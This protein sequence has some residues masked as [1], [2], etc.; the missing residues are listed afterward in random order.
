M[1][2]GSP[3]GLS[4]SVT[5]GIISATERNVVG[6]NKYESFLQTDAAINPG[7]SGGPMVDMQGRVVGINSAIVTGSRRQR[8]RRLRHPDRHGRHLADKLIKDGKVSY[9]RVG[10]KLGVAHPGDRQAVR[11]RPE[12]QGR[13][14]RRG[15]AGEPGRQ[16][17]PEGRRRHHLVQRQARR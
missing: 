15:P 7:N 17:G 3:F 14:G 9:A 6:I 16:G 8:R 5:T 12:H 2:V 10:I 11:P 13:P 4:Q 1:A